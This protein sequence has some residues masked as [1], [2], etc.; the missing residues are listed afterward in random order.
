MACERNHALSIFDKM[1]ASFSGQSTVVSLPITEPLSF[2]GMDASAIPM[3]L[4]QTS[5]AWCTASLFVPSPHRIK[6]PTRSKFLL[7]SH[8][9]T[10]P[11]SFL[12][13][14]RKDYR[15]TIRTWEQRS[16][17]LDYQFST[18]M[19]EKRIGQVLLYLTH[20]G[21]LSKNDSGY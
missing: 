13:G 11:C 12:S 14:N 6:S 5:R 4:L 18:L 2:R 9:D 16:T 17:T 19:T 3:L 15:P 8:Q 21:H 7:F 20:S 10:L 1:M